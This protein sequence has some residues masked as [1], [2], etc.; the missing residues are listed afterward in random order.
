MK[1]KI[2]LAVVL[3]LALMLSIVGCKGQKAVSSLEVIDGLKTTYELNEKPDF[4]KVRVYA[5]YND[6]TKKEVGASDLSFS[7]LD[8]SL[9]GDKKITITYEGV[10]LDIRV[11]VKGKAVEETAVLTAIQYQSGLSAEMFATSKEIDT[12]MLQ[13]LATYSDGSKGLIDNS[14][15]STNIG[16]LDFST[17]GVKTVVIKFQNFSCEFNITVKAPEIVGIEVDKN[18]INTT[19]QEGETL[20]V[21][22][23]KVYVVYNNGGRLLLSAS[24]SKLDLVS[25]MPDLSQDGDKEYTIAYDGK[26]FC[27]LIISATPAVLTGITL[28]TDNATK[29]ILLGDTLSLA[30]VGV[31]ASFSNNTSEIVTGGDLQFSYDVSKAGTSTVTVSYTYEGVTKTASYTVKVLSISKIEIDSNSVALKVPVKGD[32]DVSGLTILVTD[33][34]G[35][36]HKI[37]RSTEI[38]VNTFALN[39]NAVGK[40]YIT[41]TFRDITSEKLNITV[42]DQDVDYI[43]TKAEFPESLINWRSTKPDNMKSHFTKQDSPYYV[44]DDNAFIFTLD[45]AAYTLDGEK[46]D[47]TS[48]ISASEV[49]LNGTK[50]TGSELAKYVSIDES[51]NAFDFTE[52]A[53]GKSFTIKTRPAHGVDGIEKDCTRSLDVTVVDGYNI[54]KAYELNFITNWSDFDFTDETIKL[55]PAETRTQVEIV[56]DFI[57][58]EIQVE[59]PTIGNGIVIHGNL[60]ITPADLPAEYFV[61]RDRTKDLFDYLNVYSHMT[62]AANPNFT[63]YG[64]YF[65]INS[66]ALP[67]VCD[68]TET[69]G[70]QDEG[71]SNAQLFGFSVDPDIKW[72]EGTAFD[73]TKYS[74]T[75]KDLRVRDDN[76]NVNEPADSPR[77][78]RGLIGIKTWAQ[79]VNFE[80]TRFDRF[81][82][83]Y[84]ADSDYQ[85]VNIKDSI[86]YNSWQNHLFIWS[87]NPFY[88]ENDDTAFEMENYPVL[89][90][91]INHFKIYHFDIIF[92]N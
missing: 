15:L 83:S 51:K 54:Y 77:A 26:Y 41:V 48:Y 2:L 35:N 37:S 88:V 40:G 39:T 60:D 24:D 58:K 6:G 43:I 25:G 59:F 62:T 82:I 1:K 22:N 53:V 32:L 36:I 12:T 87:D 4:S 76:P 63:F 66:S 16:E 65:T 28:N 86:F 21:S 72:G 61:N 20:D 75:L 64:N 91:N 47:V 13:V 70:N 80:N 10:S 7:T 3:V 30:S 42:Y 78:M 8:T 85:T 23:I 33:N 14:K 74:T 89:T 71:I 11:T 31:T 18:S 34:E 67:V 19:V 29:S 68:I 92:F 38:T 9:A 52:E 45:I 84:L 57:T 79:I 27:T 90:V 69:L 44:G 56:R 50:L 55:S 49:Y 5:I 17:P 73:H 46:A 81:F